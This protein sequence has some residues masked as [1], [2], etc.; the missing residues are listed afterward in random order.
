M[1]KMHNLKTWPEVFSDIKTGLK[2]FEVRKNDRDFKVG[3]ILCLDEYSPDTH[4]YTKDQF[5]VRVMYMIQ[6]VFG[7]PKDLCVMGIAPISIPCTCQKDRKIID[8]QY[9]ER[10]SHMGF[11][12][13][14]EHSFKPDFCPWCGSKTVS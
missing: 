14:D 5:C 3:N 7:L 6:G 12:D 10:D 13:S 4:S 2:R 9:I 11:T 1:S 8:Y